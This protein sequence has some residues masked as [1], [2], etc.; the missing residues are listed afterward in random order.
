[1]GPG[2]C[3][4]CS[5]FVLQPRN[6]ELRICQYFVREM[7]ANLPNLCLRGIYYLYYSGQQA[8]VLFSLK[9]DIFLYKIFLKKQSGTKAVSTSAHKMCRNVTGK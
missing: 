9:G 7:H 5:G 4:A 3:C 2:R 6:P 8:G 1:M